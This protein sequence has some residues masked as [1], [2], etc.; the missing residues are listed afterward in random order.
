MGVKMCVSYNKDLIRDS[1]VDIKKYK[2]D[3]SP[4]IGEATIE[5]FDYKTGEKIYEAKT[6]NVINNIISKMAY[7]DYFYYKIKEISNSNYFEAP[8]NIIALFDDS[9]PEDANTVAIK[10]KLIGYADKRTPYSGSDISKGSINLEETQLDVLGDGKLHFVFDFPTHA[11]NGTFQKIAWLK[12][13]YTFYPNFTNMAQGSDKVLDSQMGI[14]YRGDKVYQLYNNTL[15]ICD[16]SNF[17]NSVDYTLGTDTKQNGIYVTETNIWTV[18]DG[19]KVYKYDLNR[20]LINTYTLPFDITGGSGYSGQL[21]HI[22]IDQSGVIL[23]TYLS[24]GVGSAIL[25]LS[26]DLQTVIAARFYPNGTTNPELTYR[27][28]GFGKFD[29][30]TLLVMC[31]GNKYSLI[32]IDTLEF[33]ARGIPQKTT[34]GWAFAQNENGKNIATCYK[35]NL[36]SSSKAFCDVEFLPLIGAETLLA[37]PITKTPTNTMKIQYDFQVEKVL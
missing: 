33:L 24:S 21:H 13:I 23:G 28:G 17:S 9:V 34:S 20:N 22:F 12:N 35:N 25:K 29:N 5:L 36:S 10:G 31:D 27:R 16:K 8:F 14:A 30:N 2:P 4:A 15:R 7:M 1:R 26:L 19:K 3:N 6:Q 32:N 18:A 11:A 37:A